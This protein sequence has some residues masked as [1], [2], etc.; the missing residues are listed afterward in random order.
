MKQWAELI[1]IFILVAENTNSE[2][3]VPHRDKVN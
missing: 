1:D 3:I 2:I